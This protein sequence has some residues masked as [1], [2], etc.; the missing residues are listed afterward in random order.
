MVQTTVPPDRLIC[1][2]CLTRGG[3]I[4]NEVIFTDTFPSLK[5]KSE[6]DMDTSSRFTARKLC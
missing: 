3:A 5:L 1:L 2:E 4:Y 6:R